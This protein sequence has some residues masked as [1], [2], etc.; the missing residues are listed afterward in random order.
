MTRDATYVVTPQ[1]PIGSGFGPATTARDVVEG[2][3]L[4][5][6]VAVVTGGYAGIGVEIT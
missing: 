3:D 2:L 1:A 6:K 4:F 5:G